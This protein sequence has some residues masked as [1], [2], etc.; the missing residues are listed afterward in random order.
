MSRSRLIGVARVL[1]VGEVKRALAATLTRE[2]EA[3]RKGHSARAT[4]ELVQTAT[5]ELLV[6][7]AARHQDPGLTRA[8]LRA[9]R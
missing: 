3:L 5:R 7:T 1:M 9:W 2:I 6:E 8:I 4:V